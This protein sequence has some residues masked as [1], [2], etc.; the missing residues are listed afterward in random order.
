[1]NLSDLSS[2]EFLASDDFIVGTIMPA[3]VIE[4]M[5]MV[6]VAIPNSTKKQAKA[7][8]YFKGAQKG[9]VV[10]KNVGREIAK[11]LGATK[12]I[13]KA[14]LGASIQLKVVGDVR[15]PDGSR[16]NAFRLHAATPAPAPAAGVPS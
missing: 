13:D 9:Y 12:N 6:D 7:V 8:M 4:R 15:R 16:G 2:S 5:Q 10:N 1:M 11:A 14:W 3:V